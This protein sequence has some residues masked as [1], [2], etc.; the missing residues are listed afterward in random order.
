MI[1][2]YLKYEWIVLIVDSSEQLLCI[3]IVLLVSAE[4]GCEVDHTVVDELLVE[5]GEVLRKVVVG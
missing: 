1:V 2:D 5:G 4:V 3:P